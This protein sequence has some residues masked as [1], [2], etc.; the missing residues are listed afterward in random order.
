VRGWQDVVSACGA[1]PGDLS[2]RCKDLYRTYWRL[3]APLVSRELLESLAAK[4]RVVACT[5]RDRWEMDRAEELLGFRFHD[6][7]TSEILRKPDPAALLRL[8]PGE[9]KRIV[10]LGDSEDDRRTA[11]RARAQ[12]SIPVEYHH[13]DHVNG[14]PAALLRSLLES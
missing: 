1:D 11:D 4:W 13:V 9:A 2:A 7:T 5:G 12:V 14:S 6:A 8:V 3:E 10:M